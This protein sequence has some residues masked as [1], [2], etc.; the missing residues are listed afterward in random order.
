MKW[1]VLGPMYPDTFADNIVATLRA[2]GHSVRAQPQEPILGPVARLKAVYVERRQAAS[3]SYLSPTESWAITEA[4]SWRPDVLLAPTQQV[5]E[6]ALV[7]LKRAGVGARVAWWADPPANMRRMGLASTEWDLLLFKDKLAVGKF[8]LAGL[9]AHLLHEAMNPVWHKPVS[10][11]L[12]DDLVFAGNW[13]GYRQLLVM[14]LLRRGVGVALYGPPPPRWAHTDIRTRFSGKY[15]TRLE[16][17]R[18]FGEALACLNS[19]STAEGDSLNCRAFEIAG[20][21]GLQLFEDRESISD[22]FSPGEEILVYGSLDEVVEYC[23][24]A[25]SEP[26]WAA[27]IRAAGAAR[28]HAHHTYRQRLE[29]IIEL[30]GARRSA[31]A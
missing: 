22:C 30:L 15:I 26:T 14:Q 19:T 8:R 13:Y 17:S 28:A 10:S 24:R 7:Q 27:R 6:E 25:R 18:V 12:N 31:A 11:H 2:M 29:R 4:R 21:G 5:R 9:N 23:A 16:K 3:A 1:L 20:A